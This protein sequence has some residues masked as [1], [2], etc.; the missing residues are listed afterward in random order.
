MPE[1]YRVLSIAG[2]VMCLFATSPASAQATLIGPRIFDANGR[3]VGAALPH[4]PYLGNGRV[5]LKFNGGEAVLNIDGRRLYLS[6]GNAA[7]DL[8]PRRNRYDAAIFFTTRNCSGPGY[9]RV[10][11][12]PNYG[13]F[14]PRGAQAP[15]YSQAGT[16]QYAAAP[17]TIA[18]LVASGSKG[19]C[20]PLWT[21]YEAALVGVPRTSV[22]PSFKLPFETK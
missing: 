21:P 6:D 5:L 12:F 10:L 17:Y 15:G 9:M 18:K 13:I 2:A 8:N 16:V 20:L 22:V 14:T 7:R 3:L 19:D 4:E 11:H 1:S